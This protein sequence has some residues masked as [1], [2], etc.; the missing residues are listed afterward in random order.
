MI[1]GGTFTS[2][3]WAIVSVTGGDGV[4]VAS[5]P[6]FA[7]A[8]AATVTAHNP[9]AASG[10]V[11]RVDG[12]G[13]TLRTRVMTN[14]LTSGE[15]DECLCTDLRIWAAVLRRPDKVATVVTNYPAL[16]EGTQQVE[17]VFDGLDPMNVDGHAGLRRHRQHRGPGP[18]EPQ[19]LAVTTRTTRGR[20][21]RPASGRRPCPPEPSSSATPPPWTGWCAEL[22][23]RGPAW[24]NRCGC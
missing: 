22:V 23:N 15:A 6:P 11:L 24:R 14:R 18:G 17:V 10:P 3:E 8:D 20:D 4:E 5:A 19:V 12:D 1:A 9:V 16:P 21:G 7:S 2:L 13:T